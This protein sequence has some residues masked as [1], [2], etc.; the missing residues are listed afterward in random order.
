MQTRAPARHGRCHRSRPSTRS[1]DS[2][3]L[4]RR[5]VR[6]LEAEI[7]ALIN[8]LAPALLEIPGCGALSASK[9]LK[10]TAGIARF[11]SKSAYARHNGTA[12]LPVWSGNREGHR[13]SRM[14]NRQLS[15]AL[16][17]IAITQAHYHPE[18]RDYLQRRRL[19]GDTSTESIRVLK[20]RLCD[21]V[22]RALRRDA[23][24]AEEPQT[25]LAAA[26]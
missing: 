16:H 12:P 1:L 10:R 26:D 4:S 25:H 14:G 19:A 13:L 24:S 3:Q 9:I 5:L 2:R 21:V 17:R 15:V 6:D 22:Y 23:H 18:A 8:R 20:R 11:K 7:T